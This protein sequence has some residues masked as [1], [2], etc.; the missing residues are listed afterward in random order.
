MGLPANE[1]TRG[2]QLNFV[3]KEAGDVIRIPSADQAYNQYDMAV[4]L[5]WCGIVQKGCLISA[6]YKMRVT[7]GIQIDTRQIAAGASFATFGG[8]V[9]Y[10]TTK[11]EYTS[12][13]AAGLFLVGYVTIP[14]N[15]EGMFRFEKRRYVIESDLT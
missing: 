11:K 14:T 13:E 9:W 10:N 2:N 6:A 5:P 12:V 15:S 4:Q 1:L 3:R 7:E 8:E